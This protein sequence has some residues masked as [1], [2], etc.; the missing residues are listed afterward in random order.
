MSQRNTKKL[1]VFVCEQTRLQRLAIKLIVACY[2][3]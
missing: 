3:T 1:L 2:R